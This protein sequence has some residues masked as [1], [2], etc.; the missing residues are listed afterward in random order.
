MFIFWA[1]D[2]T[3]VSPG[4]CTEMYLVMGALE[5]SQRH[6]HPVFHKRFFFQLK[7]ER[8]EIVGGNR[9]LLS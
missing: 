4:M 8:I 2:E 3:R 7:G 5:R 1:M 9:Y 6:S